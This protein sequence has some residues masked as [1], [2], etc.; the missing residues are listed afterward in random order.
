MCVYTMVAEC[1][2]Y[3]HS[4]FV[5]I[6]TFGTSVTHVPCGGQGYVILKGITCTNKAAARLNLNALNHSLEGPFF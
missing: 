6:P 1:E 3:F 4:K 5:T 2:N